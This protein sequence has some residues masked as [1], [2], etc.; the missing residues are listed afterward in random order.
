MND[1]WFDFLVKESKP[2]CY[3][4]A[5]LSPCSPTK[6][7]I[8]VTMTSIWKWKKYMST[9]MPIDS[10]NKSKLCINHMGSYA[11]ACAYMFTGTKILSVIRADKYILRG[12]NTWIVLE[13]SSS[14]RQN[15]LSMVWTKT[16]VFQ[17]KK[18]FKNYQEEFAQGYCSQGNCKLKFC[19]YL[20][21]NIH[22]A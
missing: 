10:W 7:D 12:I 17:K 21:R 20:L 22:T 8:A 3:P 6:L 2:S 9:Q 13:V 16:S 19:D 1:V 5:Y 18:I 14:K 4:N 15:Y 11:Y